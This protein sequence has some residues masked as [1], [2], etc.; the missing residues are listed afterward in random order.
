[1]GRIIV[2]CVCVCVVG[3]SAEAGDCDEH[4]LERQAGRTTEIRSPAGDYGGSM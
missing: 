4:Q 1:M 2:V 3:Q